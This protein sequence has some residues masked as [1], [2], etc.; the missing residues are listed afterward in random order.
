MA[1][2]IDF[3]S[4]AYPNAVEELLSLRHRKAEDQMTE[5]IQ[6]SVLVAGF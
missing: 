3:R 5:G 6:K 4:R 2:W 1:V